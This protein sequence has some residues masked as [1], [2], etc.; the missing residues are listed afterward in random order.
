MS[1]I[2][3]VRCIRLFFPY[4]LLTLGF[5]WLD[6]MWGFVL[7]GFNCNLSDLHSTHHTQYSTRVLQHRALHTNT[8]HLFP[9][10]GASWHSHGQKICGNLRIQ[11]P[12]VTPLWRTRGCFEEL[13]TEVVW[14][15]ASGFKEIFFKLQHHHIVFIS[16]IVVRCSRSITNKRFVLILVLSW[17]DLFCATFDFSKEILIFKRAIWFILFHFWFLK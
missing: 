15:R 8:Y 6:L 4:I 10:Q 2:T 11:V 3:R 17:L 1:V 12:L 5:F 13:K 7:S 16:I 9:P 14:T